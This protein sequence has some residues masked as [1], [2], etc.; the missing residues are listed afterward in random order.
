MG[1]REGEREREISR[2][3][4]RR[5]VS[6]RKRKKFKGKVNRG[7][8]GS[9][10]RQIYQLQGGGCN[11]S[12]QLSVRTCG[13][14]QRHWRS[15]QARCPTDCLR[16]RIRMQCARWRIPRRSL[17]AT[18]P[19][20]QTGTALACSTATGTGTCSAHVIHQNVNHD[21]I[22]NAYALTHSL[23]H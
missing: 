8:R 7:E 1:V 2:E 18:A 12:G 17:S 10:R 9:A 22:A 4:K 11:D 15:Q 3:R 13:R 19:R 21:T 23:T 5:R 16:V 20:P 14:C 6:E